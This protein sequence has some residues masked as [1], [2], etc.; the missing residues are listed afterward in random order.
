MN[1]QFK[2]IFSTF[3]NDN[4]VSWYTIPPRAPPFGR[5]REVAVKSLKRHFF[6]TVGKTRLQRHQF[7]TVLTQIEAIINSRPS[8]T[9]SNDVNDALALTPRHFFHR[10]TIDSNTKFYARQENI[11]Q[12]TNQSD[13]QHSSTI[14]EKL[15]S[16][17][18]DFSAAKS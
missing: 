16:R 15:E 18:L 10:M 6:R 8:V 7:P 13:W 12:S 1:K 2:E 3:T 4:S 9:S 17:I 14:L 11:D 5:L